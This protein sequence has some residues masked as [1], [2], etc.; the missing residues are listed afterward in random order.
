[1]KIKCIIYVRLHTRRVILSKNH[2]VVV[3]KLFAKPYNGMANVSF[4]MD[5][6]L[7]RLRVY[8]LLIC[9]VTNSLSIHSP[10]VTP[11]FAYFANMHICMS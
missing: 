5:F 8:S 10:K 6:Y 7:L 4:S 3:S 1:M 2:M 9:E 11:K